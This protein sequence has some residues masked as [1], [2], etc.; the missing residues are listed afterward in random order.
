[1]T[2]KISA[3]RAPT[4]VVYVWAAVLFC[5]Y[6]ALLLD[7]RRADKGADR[8]EGKPVFKPVFLGLCE[9]RMFIFLI[10]L[11]LSTFIH[12]GFFVASVLYALLFALHRREHRGRGL[13][14]RH[15]EAPASAELEA[16]GGVTLDPEDDPK[17]HRGTGYTEELPLQMQ[18]I[19]RGGAPMLAI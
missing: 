6:L 12:W 17:Q 4:T 14:P 18:V 19:E 13:P 9:A 7:K 2:T 3:F 15:P 10:F 5:I 1:M 11:V 16:E 8:G